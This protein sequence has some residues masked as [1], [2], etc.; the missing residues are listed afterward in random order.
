VVYV[1]DPEGL[2]VGDIVTVTITDADD[3][4]LYA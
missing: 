2:E 4:D 3:Y 1:A